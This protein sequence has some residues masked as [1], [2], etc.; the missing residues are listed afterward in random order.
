MFVC[1][2]CHREYKTKQNLKR[3]VTEKHVEMRHFRCIVPLC[4]GKFIR[5]SY[6]TTHLRK[7]HKFERQAAKKYADKVE[8]V[9][10]QPHTSESVHEDGLLDISDDELTPSTP[11]CQPVFEDISV[12]ELNT[13]SYD[14]FVDSLLG[15]NTI[16]EN[17]VSALT[18]DVSTEKSTS[19]MF[20]AG[21]TNF[22]DNISDTNDVSTTSVDNAVKNLIETLTES[23]VNSGNCETVDVANV[24]ETFVGDDISN[25][26]LD[27]NDDLINYELDDTN[28]TDESLPGKQ[29]DS[30]HYTSEKSD[31]ITI[32]DNEEYDEIHFSTINL[33]LCKTDKVRDNTVISTTRTASIGYSDNMSET[34]I[35]HKLKD[36]FKYV[37]DEFTEYAHHYQYNQN[38]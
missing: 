3:H 38:S 34:D 1:D 7:V 15:D 18:E 6:L 31:V 33:T 20:I 5:R 14:D 4:K 16:I 35:R 30:S 11:S 8:R 28:V 23:D 26:S 19:E 27:Y 25:V 29:N 21:E 24:S 17:T 22:C 13:C 10:H 2:T 32:S 9:A 36:I 12:D 37:H